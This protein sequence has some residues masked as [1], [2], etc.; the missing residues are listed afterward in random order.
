MDLANRETGDIVFELSNV[1]SRFGCFVAVEVFEDCQIEAVGQIVSE[2]GETER[3]VALNQNRIFGRNQ[4]LK[5][6]FPLAAIGT[7]KITVAVR[8]RTSP[9]SAPVTWLNPVCY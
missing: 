5:V 1:C 7:V 9:L 6:E 3:V 4:F 2:E 8:G